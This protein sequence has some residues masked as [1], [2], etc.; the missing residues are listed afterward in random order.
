[1]ADRPVT[2]PEP[3][4]SERGAL[5]RLLLER[6][7]R[8][9]DFTLASGARSSY[10]FDGRQVTLAG[11]GAHLVGA[12]VL[13]LARADRVSAVGGPTIGADPIVAAVATLAALDGR[14]PVDA[15][16]VRA[17][18]KAHGLGGVLVGPPLRSGQRV[19]IVDDA[20]TTGGS[21]LDAASRVRETGAEIVAAYILVD[22]EEGGADRLAEAGISVRSVFRRSQLLDATG[23]PRPDPR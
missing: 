11:A 2:D 15:F 6:S 13:R 19:A 9:G 7:F 22:R 3:G 4:A 14:G 5:A 17:A 1:V 12:A 23:R 21:L 8:F 20:L 10:Y 16:L 18:P